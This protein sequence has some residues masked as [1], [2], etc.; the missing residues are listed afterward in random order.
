M[1]PTV[2]VS[3]T[4][5][6]LP[7]TSTYC[8]VHPNPRR[9]CWVGTRV[10]SSPGILLIIALFGTGMVINKRSAPW[11]SPPM[12]NGLPRPAATKRFIC[13]PGNKNSRCVPSLHSKAPSELSRLLLKVNGWPPAAQP[14]RSAFGIPLSGILPPHFRKLLKSPNTATLG[15]KNLV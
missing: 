11:L 2:S 5:G 10:R 8:A 3:T 6:S 14:P 13:G 4:M 1:Q 7:T 12:T 15:N 9:F